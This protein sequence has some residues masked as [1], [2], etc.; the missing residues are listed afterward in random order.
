MILERLI[1]IQSK[2]SFQFKLSMHNSE[3]NTYNHLTEVYPENEFSIFNAQITL[4][5][6]SVAAFAE[7]KLK[8]HLI[9]V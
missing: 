2:P 1:K 6:N 3:C 9:Q 5:T 4:T 7:I 8:I